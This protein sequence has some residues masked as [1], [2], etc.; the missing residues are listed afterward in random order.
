[1][2]KIQVIKKTMINNRFFLIL[3]SLT[4]FLSVQ[5]QENLF[6]EFADAHKE[7]AFC[8]YPSTL[9][10]LNI[11]GN[12][13]FNEA[14]NGVEKL[15]V[16]KLDSI[17]AADRLYDGMLNDFRK[18]GFEEYISITG[19]T[20]AASLLVS[21]EDTDMQYVGVF[22]DE[23]STL[24]FYL[25]GDLKWEEIPKMFNSIKDGDFINVLDLN[26]TQFEKHP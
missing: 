3:F 19:G 7:R 9:R 26:T 13:D 14:V 16:Y 2:I 23:S 22:S 24:A 15:L 25:T 21:P 20:Y 11:S 6:K 1:M 5:G 18:K 4:V 17:S 10:M 8:F 12:P